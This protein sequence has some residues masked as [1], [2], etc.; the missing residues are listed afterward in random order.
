MIYDV[1]AEGVGPGKGASGEER[2]GR[3]NVSKIHYG[4]HI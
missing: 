1:R 2:Q 3:V 4:I